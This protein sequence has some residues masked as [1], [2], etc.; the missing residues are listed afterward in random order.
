MSSGATDGASNDLPN[1][2]PLSARHIA[3]GT[4]LGMVAGLVPKDSA[5]FWAAC[6]VV[7]F[8]NASF[9]AAVGVAFVFSLVGPLADP[10]TGWVG[11]F[12]LTA[13]AIQPVWQWLAG[14]PVASWTRFNNTVVMGSL[15]MAGVMYVPVYQLTRSLMSVHGER[16]GVRMER[17]RVIRW[18]SSS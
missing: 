8:S 18:L 1:R 17:S 11:G 4:A 7:L 5:F 13:D 10:I 3:C 14:L 2:F 6:L 16:I 12:L 15:V 9:Y